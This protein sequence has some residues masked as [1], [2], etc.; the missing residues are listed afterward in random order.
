[1]G[2]YHGSLDY[3]SSH[4]DPKRQVSLLRP[5][6]QLDHIQSMFMYSPSYVHSL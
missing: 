1:M 5:A 6:A 4:I 2:E 3:S